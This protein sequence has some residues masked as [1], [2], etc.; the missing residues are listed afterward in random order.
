MGELATSR[1]WDAG[2]QECP[3]QYTRMIPGTSS[4]PTPRFATRDGERA[5]RQTS[6]IAKRR[7]R[8]RATTT[9]Q[10]FLQQP[11]GE[12][13]TLFQL[14][15]A[16]WLALAAVGGALAFLFPRAIPW[17]SLPIFTT[18]VTL[19]GFSEGIYQYAGDPLSRWDRPSLG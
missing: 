8:S 2:P 5:I 12:R 4:M 13:F 10:Q 6:T 16:D 18:L 17:T 19:F 3:S 1:L 7:I 11:T 14:L 15:A 9:F